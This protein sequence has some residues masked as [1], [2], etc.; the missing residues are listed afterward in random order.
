MKSEIIEGKVAKILN[1]RELVINRGSKN[2]VIV[3]MKFDVMDSKGFD[4][5]DPDTNE[6]LGSVARP[7]VRVEVISVQEQLSV[8]RTFKKKVY[9]VG[10]TGVN[11][12][13]FASVLMPPRW[14]TEYE[15]LKTKE[16]TWEDLDEA[17]SYVKI[18]DPLIEIREDKIINSIT[19][20]QK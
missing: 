1:S 17:D 4:I 3:G 10:G 12:S 2:G 14:V 7:K 8:A 15:T 11:L 20:D 5:K 6:L 13:S 9:N 18:G 16:A 19:E